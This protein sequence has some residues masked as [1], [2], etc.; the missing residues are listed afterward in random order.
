MANLFLSIII[1]NYNGRQYLSPCFE[2]LQRQT[3]HHLEI[4]L[5]D[6]GSSDDSVTL[7]RQMFP[8]VKIL[9]LDQNFGFTGA[10]NRGIEQACGDIIVSLNNDTEADPNWAQS[11]VTRLE[12]FPDA[13]IVASKM[14]LFS[15]RRKIH[16]AGDAFG[17]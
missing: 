10:L 1:P 14:L 9:A 5:V 16:S 2:A 3:Y 7:T 12:A 17:C 11:L 8:K 13:G 6:N 15:D 4:I